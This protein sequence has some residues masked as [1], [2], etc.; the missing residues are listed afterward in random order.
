[1]G[2]EKKL[3]TPQNLSING[4]ILSWDP[5]ENAT[6]YDIYVDNEMA[7]TV[8]VASKTT[9]LTAFLTGIAN[10]LRTKKG[11]TGLINPQDFESEIASIQTGSTIT[12]QTKTATPTKGTQTIMP[13]TNYGGLSSVTIH[14]IPDEY[15]TTNDATAT[16]S[17][18]KKD[19]TAYVNGIKL[20]GTFTEPTVSL[21]NKTITPTKSEQ[22]IRADTGYDGLESVKV[23]AIPS[24]YI[25][26]T[27][28][29][30][31]EADILKGKTA[32][33]KGALITGTLT[34][35]S[36]TIAVNGTTS[37]ETT[38]TLYNE[39]TV[40]VPT[41]GGITE[42]STTDEMNSLLQDET[43]IGKMYRYVGV[44][45]STYTKGDIY[46]VAVL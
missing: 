45:N 15:I 34:A 46:E 5:V 25:D 42:I 27:S 8:T 36:I 35:S 41:K 16:A 38:G 39:I 2:S 19:K 7:A 21:Q 18:I 13:D 44:T 28:G 12:L 9:N 23:G 33:T 24:E 37:S 10:A 43:N 30:A 31:T 6:S 14:P 4:D 40:K 26:T 17:D 20:Q 11:T 32:Y 29:T 3:D 22:T 1:M